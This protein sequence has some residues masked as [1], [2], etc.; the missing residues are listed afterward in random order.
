VTVFSD[1]GP[2]DAVDLGTT[3]LNDFL[4]TSDG[5][6]FQLWLELCLTW[7]AMLRGSHSPD[8]SQGS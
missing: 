3:A 5:S 1:L 4:S 8:F 6:V 7:D 2:K